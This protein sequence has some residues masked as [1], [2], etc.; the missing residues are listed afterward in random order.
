[1]ANPED[2]GEIKDAS[3]VESLRAFLNANSATKP[4]L[5]RD[6]ESKQTIV[7]TTG[8]ILVKLIVLE[9]R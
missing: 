3:Q 9:H 7:K 5:R 8:D 2:K 6:D 1:L 4:E